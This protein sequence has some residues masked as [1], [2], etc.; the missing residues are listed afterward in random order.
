MIDVKQ[1]KYFIIYEKPHKHSI[2]EVS[3]KH[4]I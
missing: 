1:Q 2:I 3:N 4:T